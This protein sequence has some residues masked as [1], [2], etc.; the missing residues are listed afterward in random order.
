M[1]GLG[2]EC[3]PKRTSVGNSELVVMPQPTGKGFVA[4]MALTVAG[5]ALVLIG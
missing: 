1:S 3:A 4:G 2:L 5:V